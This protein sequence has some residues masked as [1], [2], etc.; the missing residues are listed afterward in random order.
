MWC[1][2]GFY[3]RSF[4]LPSI[5]NNGIHLSSRL[6]KFI[7]FADDIDVLFSDLDM[8]QDIL[9]SEL[10]KVSNCLM[11]DKLT[12]NIKKTMFFCF[13]RCAKNNYPLFTHCAFQYKNKQRNL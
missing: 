8:L 12:I 9:N 13:L 6:L 7:P 1:S 3:P 4:T 10:E 5:S 2:T 11:A